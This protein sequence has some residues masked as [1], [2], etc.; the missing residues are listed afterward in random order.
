MKPLDKVSCELR[1]IEKE[2]DNYYKSNPLVNLPFATAACS[3][4]AFAELEMLKQASNVSTSQELG[5]QVD[6]FVNEL[7]AP[8]FWLFSA[9]ERGGQIPSTCDDDVF[10]ASWDLFKLG[11]KYQWFEAAYTYAS[12]GLIKLELEGSTIQPAKEFFKGMEYQAY[13]RLMKAHESDEAVSLINVDNFPLLTGAISRS[14]RIKGDRF[15]CKMNPRVV[16]DTIKFINPGYDAVFSLR[17]EWRF[18]RYTLGDFRKVFEAILAMAS[19]H[20]IAWG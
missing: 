17:S 15:F 2:I 12:N 13:G 7:K 10:Q 6:N 1:E 14:V 19:I 16:S 9:C 20:F 18:S 11:K 5:T 3:F 4:L 8:M